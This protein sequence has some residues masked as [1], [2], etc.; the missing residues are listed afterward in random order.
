MTRFLSRHIIVLTHRTIKTRLTP[1]QK[2]KM[3]THT[4]RKRASNRL[5]TRHD[6]AQIITQKKNARSKFNEERT[7]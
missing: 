4:Q 3:H 7:S 6:R 2:I 5:K 1:R